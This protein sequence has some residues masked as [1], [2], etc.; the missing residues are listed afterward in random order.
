MHPVM[1]EKALLT[2]KGHG[3]NLQVLY[4]TQ[5]RISETNIAHLSSVPECKHGS[6]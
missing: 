2:C 4:G 5:A 3:L 1:T 6:G